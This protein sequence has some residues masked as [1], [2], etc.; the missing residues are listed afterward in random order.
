VRAALASVC[1]V[2]LLASLAGAQDTPPAPDKPQPAPRPSPVMAPP[3]MVGAG[4]ARENR[5][6]PQHPITW[7]IKLEPH[8]WPRSTYSFEGRIETAI[9]NVSFK[10]PPEYQQSFDFWTGRMKDTD[11]SEMILQNTSTAEAEEGGAVPFHRSI[12]RFSLDINDR[13]QIKTPF[14]EVPAAVQKLAWD[15]KLDPQGRITESRRT[16]APE[17]TSTIDRLAFP[18]LDHALPVLDAARTL[19]AGETIVLEESMP[20]PSR[21]T[22]AG[23]EGQAVLMKR[24]LTPREMEGEDITFDVKTTYAAD[25]ATPPKAERTTCV[26]GGGGDG[27]AVFSRSDGVFVRTRLTSNLIIDIEAPLR[28]LPNQAPGSDP[29]SASVHI[30]MSLKMNGKQGVVRLFFPPKS[31]APAP[32]PAAGNSPGN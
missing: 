21:L 15:G 1:A 2:A 7:P 22:I 14:S 25:P 13:G 27:E 30:E 26:I 29:G 6:A 9:G 31:D 18:V 20:L 16:A 17:D 8:V 24:V 12:S 3:S 4:A 5:P 32:T 23:L 10:A 11:R 28:A 19:K